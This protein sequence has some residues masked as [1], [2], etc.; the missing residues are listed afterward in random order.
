MRT[1]NGTADDGVMN[2]GYTEVAN[3]IDGAKG[4]YAQSTPACSPSRRKGAAK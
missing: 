3:Q 1:I 2:P 4:P